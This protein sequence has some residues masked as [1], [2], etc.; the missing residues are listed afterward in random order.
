LNSSALSGLILARRSAWLLLWLAAWSCFLTAGAPS[1]A[2]ALDRCRKTMDAKTLKNLKQLRLA[3]TVHQDGRADGQFTLWFVRPDRYRLDLQA[4]GEALC[5]C[6]NG[7]SA[8]RMDGAAVSS[9]IDREAAELLSLALLGNYRWTELKKTP[10]VLGPRLGQEPSAQSRAWL[11]SL[12]LQGVTSTARIGQKQFQLQEWS[13]LGADGA[14]LRQAGDHRLRQGLWVPHHFTIRAGSRTFHLEVKE[15]ATD[16]PTPANLFEYPRGGADA[17]VPDLPALLASLQQ[18]QAEVERRREQFTCRKTEQTFEKGPDGQDKLKETKV[19]DVTPVGSQ[20]IDRLISVDGKPLS[21]KEQAKEDRRVEKEIRELLA[22]KEKKGREVSISVSD[23]LRISKISSP[24]C[25]RYRGH[26][27]IVFDF[28]P[29]PEYRPRN[30]DEEIVAK[31]AGH[32]W[33]DGR[34]KQIVR[35]A[36]HFTEKFSI[37][38]GLLASISPSTAV[39]IQQEKINDEVWMPSLLDL[40]LS[41]RALFF[42]LTLRQVLR[43]SDYQRVGVSIDYHIPPAS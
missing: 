34:E 25:E 30:R 15:A 8:W 26:E 12:F 40:N 4:G 32:I 23:F 43:Y 3:G 6:Y 27:G 35:L 41:G 10:F 24:R 1:P 21:P 19:F 11:A 5:E 31:L 17:P 9:L 37:G 39:V 33:V 28:E 42:K 22:K 2:K 29:R 14:L 7:K 38:L 18:N 20:F 16:V 13:V 36:A